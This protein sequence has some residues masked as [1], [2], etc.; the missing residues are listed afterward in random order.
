MKNEANLIKDEIDVKDFVPTKYS[1]Y[2]VSR[3]GRV[4][5]VETKR[6]MQQFDNGN[7]YLYSSLFINGKNKKV[8][9]SILV[10]EAFIPKPSVEPGTKLDVAHLDNDRKN[11]N[12]S[13][14]AWKTRSENLDTES[15]REK[16]QY[17]IYSKVRCIETG[18][19]F[20]S[21]AAAGRAIGI[22]Q[23]GINLC[24]LGRQKT[25]GGYHWERVLE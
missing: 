2:Y 12:V 4:M 18:E 7:G 11:N 21:I 23:Y 17:K 16:A 20:P 14:L 24:L 19:I 3:D 25:A 8:R 9:V 6:I 22:H 10:A 15:F 5:N 13:N 1:K